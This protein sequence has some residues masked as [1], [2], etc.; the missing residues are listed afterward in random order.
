M[1]VG[2]RS[3]RQSRGEAARLGIWESGNPTN[4]NGTLVRAIGLEGRCHGVFSM[5]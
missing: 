2:Q 4:R 3:K 1:V 5:Q